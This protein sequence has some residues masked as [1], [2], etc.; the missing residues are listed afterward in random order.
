M[1]KIIA[2]SLTLM[3]VAGS[4]NAANAVSKSTRNTLLALGSI[5]ALGYVAKSFSDNKHEEDQQ[6]QYQNRQ[7]SDTTY[8]YQRNT[9]S[10]CFYKQLYEQQRDGSLAPVNVKI[11]Q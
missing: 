6:R 11:C 5:A 1:K 4:M 9:S 3:L 10:R 8:Q 7:Y 2:F